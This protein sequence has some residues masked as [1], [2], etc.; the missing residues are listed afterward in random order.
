MTADAAIRA[1][2]GDLPVPSF[3]STPAARSVPLSEARVAIV[4]TAGLRLNGHVTLWQPTDGSFT[5]L[6][7]DARD[8]QLSHFSP[9]FDR[10]G[11]RGRP[12]RGASDRS[13][14]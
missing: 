10:T 1:R 11:F 8:M 4:T 2:V 9:N 7:A 3:D 14:Q 5:V 12:Q 13:T 6:P